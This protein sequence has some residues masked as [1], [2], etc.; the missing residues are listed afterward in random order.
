MSDVVVLLIKVDIMLYRLISYVLDK[1][2]L[3]KTYNIKIIK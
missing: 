3:I 2:P 1:I